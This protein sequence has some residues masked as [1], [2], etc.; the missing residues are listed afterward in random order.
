M[1][2]G[3]TSRSRESDRVSSLVR[4]M[5]SGTRA[6]DVGARTGNIS[7]L[8]AANFSEVVALDLKKPEMSH[9]RIVPVQGDA[10]D[11]QFPDNSI[12]A[13][14]CAELL[15]HLLP[16]V[17]ERV[18]SELVRVTKTSLVIGVPFKQDTRL[19]RT[20]CLNCGK[21][22]PPWGHVNTFD[23]GS[24]TRL[25]PSLAC[26]E[27]DFVGESD[28]RTNWIST[29]LLD[30]AGNPYGTYDQE[31][32]CVHCGRP[33]T[34]PPNRNLIQKICTAAASNLQ[35]LQNRFTRPHPN[36]IHMRF[37]KPHL[38]ATTIR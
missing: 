29:R 5:R 18:V 32:T 23:E 38:S 12:D 11:L 36:W 9:P 14:L 6:L 30:Y 2:V 33:L 19:G 8:L 20:T 24:L 31:E 27:V 26:G 28:G 35:A 22:N 25:F 10:A 34:Q 3:P 16:P 17:L 1:N 13:V 21:P 7:L 4:L 37:D 15:E